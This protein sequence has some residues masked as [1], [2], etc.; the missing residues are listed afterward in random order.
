MKRYKQKTPYY[1]IPVPGKDDVIDSELEMRKATIIENML[2][3][4]TYGVTEVVFEDGGYSLERDGENFLVRLQANGQSPSATGLLEGFFFH[5]PPEIRW[6]G[7][8]AGQKYYLYLKSML[9]MS[10]Q[11]DAVRAVAVT[12]PLRSRALLLATLDLTVDDPVV[13]AAPEGKIFSR[14]LAR[15]A[16][17]STNPHGRKLVQDELMVNHLELPEGSTI[18]AGGNAVSVGVFAQMAADIAGRKVEIVEFL[19]AGP[20]GAVLKASGRVFHVEVQRVANG[21][22]NGIQGEIGVG[23]F[24]VDDNVDEETEFAV[25][26][27]G[28]DAIPMRALVIC[29]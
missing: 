7:L 15:H 8:V 26:N 6:E 14:D 19:S 18:M 20:N 22:L 5:G 23:Y 2:R 1:G 3:A 11:N 9:A 4:G 17:D 10:Y 12:S 28:Q 29:G 13:N 16:S 25:Y 21:P 27:T 24:G